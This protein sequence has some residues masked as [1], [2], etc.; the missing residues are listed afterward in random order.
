MTIRISPATHRAWSRLWL[1]Q[2]KNVGP[3][4]ALIWNRYLQEISRGKVGISEGEEV[5]LGVQKKNPQ[6]VGTGKSMEKG[7][8][9]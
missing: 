5:K 4:P 3:P 7:D 8:E 9:A 1:L 6:R 2:T